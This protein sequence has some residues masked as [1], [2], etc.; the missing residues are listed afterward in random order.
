[1]RA[2]VLAA[3][4]L[5]QAQPPPAFSVVSIKPTIPGS[6][7]GPG[8]YVQTTPGHFVARGTLSFF[9]QYAYGLQ[10]FQ[11]VGGPDWMATERYD[12]NATQPESTIDFALMPRM[13]QAAL[14]DRFRMSVTR[15]TRDTQGYALVST[16]RPRLTPSKPDDVQNS[17]G[18]TGQL[19]ST[20]ATMQQLASFLARATASP[21]V[22]RT[23]LDG[24]YNFTLKW[25]PDPLE[26]N[27]VSIFTALQEQ[28]GLKLEQALAP[29][30]MLVIERAARPQPD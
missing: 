30:D 4:V 8:P 10:P 27:G 1:M 23:G 18:P 21:V 20:K 7:G 16:G 13:L 11:I 9:I 28:L 15:G 26:P 22:N 3:A 5:L 12:I 6:R 25:T 17:R 19:I 2:L 29:I 14:T 24:A